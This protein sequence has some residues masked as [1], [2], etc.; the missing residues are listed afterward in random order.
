MKSAFQADVH[1]E[2]R[3]YRIL[4]PTYVPEK[5]SA[6]CVLGIFSQSA[7]PLSL[8]LRTVIITFADFLTTTT[9]L[10]NF[11]PGDFAPCD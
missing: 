11:S 6:Q 7:K 4:K 1:F 3:F 8:P 9:K 2:N 5:F 10:G